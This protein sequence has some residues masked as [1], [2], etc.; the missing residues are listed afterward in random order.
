MKED[1]S[2]A[3]AVKYR[4]LLRGYTDFLG[5]KEITPTRRALAETISTLQC[6]L[7]MLTD[8]FASS[9]RGGSAEDIA[10]FLRLSNNISDLLQSAGLAPSQQ[11]IVDARNGD[12]A[13]EVLCAAFK[14]LTSARTQDEAAGIFRDGTGNVITDPTRLAIAQQI[15]ALAQ[16]AKAIDSGEVPSTNVETLLLAP[17]REAEPAAPAAAP[18]STPN[19]VDLKAPRA[20]ETRR[21]A[22][23]P[24]SPAPVVADQSTKTSTDLFYEHDATG[25]PWW[26]PV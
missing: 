4:E 24:S 13:L 15:Y 20:P 14:K 23:E 17:P 19:V 25:R 18:A 3:W 16:M 10:L 26:G 6:E 8:R 7:S 5:G 1:R 22:P 2:I 21:R 12:D 11:P 9:G